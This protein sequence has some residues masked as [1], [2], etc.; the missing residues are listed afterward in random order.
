MGAVAN[1]SKA[2]RKPLLEVEGKCSLSGNIKIG[3]AKNSAL[4]LM[5]ASLLTDEEIQI[6]NVPLLTDIKVMTDILLRMGVETKRKENKL[7]IDP[8]NLRQVILPVKLVHSLR[9]SF[10]CIGPLLAKLGKAKL[11]LPGGCKIGVRPVDQHI[12]GLR[13]LGASVQIEKNMISAFIPEGKT[14]LDG[15]TILLDCPSVGATET[16]LMAASLARGTTTIK[17]AAKEPEVQDLVKMLNLMGAKI[18]GAGTSKITINGVQKLNGCSHQAI[19]DRI[20]AGTFLIAAAITK[21]TLSIGPVIPEHL[22]AVINKLRECGCDIQEEK[23]NYLKIIPSTLKAVD[24]ITQPFP[25][26][27]TDLQAP[28]MALMSIA[29]G[30]SKIT[31]TIFENRMQHVLELK[32]MGASIKINDSTAIINGVSSLN[33]TALRGGDLRSTAAIILASLSAKGKSTIQGLNHLD[34]GYEA[35]E[36]KLNLAGAN[37]IRYLKNS[38]KKNVSGCEPEKKKKVV[39]KEDA[40]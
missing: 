30:K 5:A 17:N 1:I 11:A 31:E 4:V 3:G 21:S 2:I 22:N 18:S 13:A 33:S 28:F 14:R 36:E 25:G 27:P 32:K 8:K 15:A 12:K 6:N 38:D 7:I 23:E 19:P 20:E 40:A 10:F 39:I 29:K 24:V 9:A 26:F 37:I 16:I 34:R 35:F